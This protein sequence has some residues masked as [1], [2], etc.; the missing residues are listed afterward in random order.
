MTTPKSPAPRANAGSRANSKTKELNHKPSAIDLEPDAA[1]IWFAA[2][3]SI[4]SALARLVAALASLGRAVQRPALP[5]STQD[6]RSAR[7]GLLRDFVFEALAPV[8]SDSGAAR[9]C[10]KHDDDAGAALPP[11]AGCR[12]RQGDDFDLPR[13]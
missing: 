3:L 6:V 2:R 5:E 13:A 11:Q 7:A 8:E 9:L 10:L 4:P 1:A 12:V